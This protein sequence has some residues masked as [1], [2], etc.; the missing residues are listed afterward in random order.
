MLIGK[1]RLPGVVYVLKGNMKIVL[2]FAKVFT[3]IIIIFI[4]IFILFIYYFRLSS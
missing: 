4:T 3:N 1:Y 2:M